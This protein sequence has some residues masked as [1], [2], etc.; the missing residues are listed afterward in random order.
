MTP[1]GIDLGTTFSA[2]AKWENIPG[3]TG[4]K[5]Y[6]LPLEGNDVLPSKIVIQDSGDVIYGTMAISQ[7]QIEPRNFFSAFKRGMD[8][9]CPLIRENGEEVT[10]VD[11]SAYI[12]GELLRVV[13][14]IENPGNY[15]P[16]C[17]VVSVPYYFKQTQNNNTTKA[18]LAALNKLYTGRL[19]GNTDKLFLQLIPEPVAAGL[20]YAFQHPNEEDKTYLVFDLGGGTFDVT[21]YKQ[22]HKNKEIIF[23]VLAIGGNDRLGGEDFDESLLNFI[24]EQQGLTK[25]EIENE[26]KREHIFRDLITKI[27]NCKHALSHQNVTPLVCP[28]FFRGQFLEMQISRQDLEGC[29]NGDKGNKIDY[30]SKIDDIVT[31]TIEMAEIKANEISAVLLVGGSS[32]IPKIKSSLE[33]RFGNNRIL[34]G[35]LSKSVAKG[36]ALYAAYLQDEKL[37]KAGQPAK[38]MSIWDKIVIKE[39]T[40]H[41]IGIITN[42]GITDIVIV[43]NS[44]APAK[45]IKKYKPTNISEDGKTV[46][47]NVISIAQGSPAKS[48]VIGD[49]KVPPI[50]THGRSMDEITITVELISDSTIVKARILVPNGAED[51]T[52]ICIEDTISLLQ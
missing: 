34:V 12:I 22:L 16:D 24:F 38:Y 32:Q 7:G 45:G 20:D 11:L 17:L 18:V 52:D 23:E 29:L 4:S 25:K 2:I 10:P 15:T 28:H 50:Y 48:N 46:E 14:T 1:I 43:H 49:I 44:V 35:D 21:I 26:P 6:T 13:E 3:F 27:T 19:K 31:S 5:T 8:E 30:L 47:L 33:R 36:A 51:M 39:R 37:L 9:N 41:D 40:A 42:R